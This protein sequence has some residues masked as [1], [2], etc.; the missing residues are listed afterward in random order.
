MKNWLLRLRPQVSGYFL[1]RNFF[2]PDT[3]AAH[4]HPANSTANP[5]ILNP[6]A[7]VGKNKFSTNPTTCG[8]VNPD[9]FETDDVTNS[10]PDSY[11]TINQYGGTTATIVP[12][13]HCILITSSHKIK[14]W[15]ESAPALAT[16]TTTH[17]LANNTGTKRFQHDSPL[18]LSIT[19]IP[20]TNH[21]SKR[22]FKTKG[23]AGET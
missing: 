12:Y 11:R 23:G 4:S 13:P 1:I 16:T 14:L 3:A 5:D 7:R 20:L 2:F 6:L 17:K 8:R 15:K 9:I 21:N 10:C 22:N 18:I 19:Q